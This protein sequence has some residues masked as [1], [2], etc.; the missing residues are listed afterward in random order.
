MDTTMA[1]V[2]MARSHPSVAKIALNTD[3]S[4]PV[5]VDLAAPTQSSLGLPS[6]I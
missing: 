5:R 4:A 3:T 1:P 2:S 6:H